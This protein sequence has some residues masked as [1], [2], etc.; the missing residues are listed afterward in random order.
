M[1]ATISPQ[2]LA[3]VGA[4]L[5]EGRIVLFLGAGA[6]LCG[7]PVNETWEPGIWMPN[8]R[9]LAAHLAER[10]EVTP[11]ALLEVAEVVSSRW[12]E[13]HLARELRRVFAYDYPPTALHR[14]LA[15]VPRLIRE[16]G[17]HREWPLFVTT[18]YD[19]L[20]ER[21]F[22]ETG[23]PYDLVSYDRRS[24][25]SSTRTPFVHLSPAGEKKAIGGKDDLGLLDDRPVI[26]KIHGSI[27]R[28]EPRLD[29]YVISEP[30]Y[31]DLLSDD[32]LDR[33][34]VPI[35]AKLAKSPALFLGYA[36]RDWDV[37]VALRRIQHRS[38]GLSRG[39]FAVELPS[40]PDRE[41]FLEERWR[42][43]GEY[44]VVFSD[45]A[46]YIVGLEGALEA[47]SPG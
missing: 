23:E 1:P 24:V 26:F 41:R 31:I 29:S 5:L 13:A 20:L 18:N 45:L 42:R 27:D 4:R 38:G 7:R 9:E 12:S 43:I 44:E 32:T 35:Q 37:M 8:A 21:A 17:M 16:R 2:H 33:I 25:S 40:E 11:G 19:D 3:V 14:L 39:G 47:S 34:P 30:D 22:A 10:F 28:A 46:E 36:M 15:A 6:N